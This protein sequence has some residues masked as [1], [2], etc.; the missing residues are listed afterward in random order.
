M[1]LACG[2]D[3]ER[4]KIP[5]KK[6]WGSSP[7][8]GRLKKSHGDTSIY[9]NKKGVQIMVSVRDRFLCKKV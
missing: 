4:L 8:E 9:F 6:R 3:I 1:Y 2:E 5:E 7:G